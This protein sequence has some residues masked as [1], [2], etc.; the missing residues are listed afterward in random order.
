[1]ATGNGVVWMTKQVSPSLPLQFAEEGRAVFANPIVANSPLQIEIAAAAAV[2]DTERGEGIKHCLGRR[3]TNSSKMGGSGR[4][5]IQMA[6]TDKRN[7]KE[8]FAIQFSHFDH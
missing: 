6:Q 7:F 2:I 4:V 8:G 3:I 5:C 1:M